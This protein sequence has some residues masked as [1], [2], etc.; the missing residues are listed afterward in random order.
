[1]KDEDYIILLIN[2]IMHRIMTVTYL[3]IHGFKKHTFKDIQPLPK[4]ISVCF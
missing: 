3:S 1:M 2:H 4:P